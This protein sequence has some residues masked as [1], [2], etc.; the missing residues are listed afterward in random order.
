MDEVYD[1]N[2]VPRGEINKALREAKRKP[3]L[4]KFN[5]RL[6]KW[7]LFVLRQSSY[8]VAMLAILIVFSIERP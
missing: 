4:G 8:L 7:L 2:F 6:F 1:D 3:V 5:L